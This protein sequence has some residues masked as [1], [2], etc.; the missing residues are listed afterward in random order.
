MFSLV[1]MS[2]CND[3]IGMFDSGVGG[4]TIWQA[5]AELLPKEPVLYF[6]DTAHCPYGTRTA[7]EV[8]TFCNLITRFLLAR[9]C[10][11]I[12][13]A[14]NTATAM[15][16]DGLRRNFPSVP[17]VGIE[18]A[19]KPAALKSHSG[20]IGVLA[21]A[22]T[23]QGRLFNETKAR[24]AQNVR[25]LTAEGTGLV[26]LVEAG[27]ADSAEAEALLRRALEPMLTAGM[28]RLVLGCTH[29]PFL[30][31]TIRRIVG[32]DVELI[33]P[34]AAVARQVQHLLEA[35]GLLAGAVAPPAH[36]FYS[37]GGSAVLAALAKCPVAS[38]KYA[39]QTL[40]A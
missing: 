6:A 19:V 15:A 9:G 8:A 33:T 20:V 21:T 10:K 2:L 17:F 23:F 7:Q 27:K 34:G 18:P 3:P 38:V 16:I 14:C 4:L 35:R 37:S 25:V 13:V 32:T 11:L 26:E 39:G 5:V 1:A 29:Y 28:D 24:F 31:E 12:V 30:G 40:L 22:G 36:Q